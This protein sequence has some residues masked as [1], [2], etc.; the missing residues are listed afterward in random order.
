MGPIDYL[1]GIKRRWRSITI[2]VLLAFAGAAASTLVY[3]VR[4]A[5]PIH[6]ATATLI[7]SSVTNTVGGSNKNSSSAASPADATLAVIA[8]LVNFEPVTSRVAKAISYG[9]APSRLAAKVEADVDRGNQNL[10]RITA[11][12]SDASSATTLADAFATALISYLREREAQANT[13]QQKSLRDQMARIRREVADLDRRL[14]RYPVAVQ[15]SA[16][17]RG[18]TARRT[19][20]RSPA[21]PLIEERDAALKQLGT[22][23][24]QY[25]EVRSRVVDADG[26][27]LFQKARLTGFV[28]GRIPIPRSLP[29]R[30]GIALILGIAAGAALSI[31]RDR[32]DKRIRTREAVEDHFGYPVLVEVPS[33]RKRSKNGSPQKPAEMSPQ[34]ADAFRVLGAGL[35]SE[36]AGNGSEPNGAPRKV[37]RVILVT[38]ASP[39]EGKTTVVAN[40]ASTLAGVG[41]TV[42]VLSADFRHPTLHREYG[43]S[44]TRGLAEALRSSNGGSVLDGCLWYTAVSGVWLVP[45]GTAADPPDQLLA[46]AAMRRAV[47]EARDRS[48]MVLIDMSPVLTSDLSFLLPQVDSV[49]LVAK[50]GSST[51]ELAERSGELLKR[52]GAPVAGVVL[53]G[54]AATSLPRSY[55]RKRSTHEVVVAAGRGTARLTA[56]AARATWR[57]TSWATRTIRRLATRRGAAVGS[58]PK[59][60]P[61]LSRRS[62]S[63]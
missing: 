4:G 39:S 17:G 14:A 3:S 47:T 8:P 45:S 44:N 54:D 50:A 24:A 40:L 19:A 30:F 6:L 26:L 55:Y 1:K 46:S 22:V 37:P 48:D 59:G 11:R 32:F 33:V 25:Q 43:V 27:S 21:D 20:T 53:I 23:S 29:I 2:L 34:V 13:A 16:T 60:F 61:R 63:E 62:P 38:S 57:G 42:M 35:G 58:R 15:Q 9:R 10:L 5:P 18:T 41:K 52:L 12:S 56:R 51:P 31:A 49:L 36:A 7:Q 28:A